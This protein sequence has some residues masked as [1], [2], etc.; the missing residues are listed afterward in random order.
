MFAPLEDIAFFQRVQVDPEAGTIVWPNEVDF[1]PDVLYSWSLGNPYRSS[2]SQRGMNRRPV[3]ADHPTPSLQNGVG[4]LAGDIIV[5][6]CWKAILNLMGSLWGIFLF[7]PAGVAAVEWTFKDPKEVVSTEHFQW[8]EVREGL[9]QGATEW[10]P[11]FYLRLPAEGL[12]ARRFSRL[13][14]RLYSSAPADEL[15]IYYRAPNGQWA[16]GKSW[17][18]VA[19][20]A[21]YRVDLNQADWSEAGSAASQR[22]GGEEK[23]VLSFRLDPGN[24]EGRWIAVQGVRLE[25]A[26]GDF[27]PGCQPEKVGPGRLAEVEAPAQVTAGEEIPVAVRMDLEPSVPGGHGTGYLWLRRGGAVVGLEVFPVDLADAEVDGQARFPTSPYAMPG[28]FTLQAG[29]LER[30]VAGAGWGRDLA[31]V[32][33]V[34]PRAGTVQPP[35]AEVRPLGG[36][37]ALFV[38]GKPVPAFLVSTNSPQR[39]RRHREFAEAGLH[40]YSDWFGT[41]GAGDLGQVKAGIYDYGTYDRYFAE[42]LQA[43]P[44]AYFLPH[45]GITAPLWWQEAHPEERCLYADGSRGPS[46]F[47]SEKWRQETAEDLRRLIHH[48]QTAPYADRILGYIPY[49]GYSAEWQS[50][51]LWD[52][53]LADYSEPARRAWH[54]WLAQRYPTDSALQAA[55]H[56]PGVARETAPLPTPEQRH[57]AAWG[58]LRDPASERNV[59]DFY[60]FLAQLTAETIGYFARVI[61]EAC[62]GR[63]LVGTYYGYLTQH[64][65]RQQDSS[66]LALAQVL[67]FP[68]VDFL[69]SP[70]LY[71]GRELGGTPGFMSATESVLRHGKLWLSEA[72]YRTYLSDPAAGYGR[73]DT[74][75]T[76]RAVLWREFGHVLTHRSAVSW[77]DMADG[78]LSGPD[79]RRELG[80]MQDLLQDSLLQREPFH[81]D[82]AVVVDEASFTYLRPRHEINA[83]LSL[84][85]VVAMP[86]VGVA[87]DFYLLS[88]LADP[89]LPPHKLYLFLN[90]FKV[91]EAQRQAL[92][93]RLRREGAT[94]VWIYAAGFY[95]EAACGPAEMARLTG[96]A[97]AQ[98]QWE[99]PLWV[100]K[101]DHPLVAGLPEATLAGA[102]VAISPAFV[103]EDAAADGLGRLRGSAEVGLAR[104]AMDGWTSIYCAAPLLTPALLRQLARAAGA[105]VYLETGDALSVDNRFLCLHAAADGD[106]ALHLPA[107]AT[108][109]DALSGVVLAQGT[110]FVTLPMRR[111]ETRLLEILSP[112][113][114]AP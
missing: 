33:L 57:A 16:L 17:P 1:C 55:W 93:A 62:R 11:Y 47:A 102:D 40:L 111:G 9:F 114:K 13:T 74:P 82:V 73:T 24:Q 34:N 27:V 50:W 7:F 58:V 20:W 4:S 52:D 92:H 96:I 100:E 53:H 59:I 19:G 22:W 51:G 97:V 67:R 71:T 28:D 65:P 37:P 89:I 3:L 108:V 5:C 103:V 45:I 105:H 79:L 23:R 49:S 77:Y 12:D 38:N 44:Q 106:K 88:D 98:R 8:A 86:R 70:P 78:W 75:A 18:I 56:Q 107:P 66:H 68:E 41:S 43:D 46:S 6:S 32:K 87:W 10:D 104:R 83:L 2:A 91:T 15:S 113:R 64:G 30:D 95:G 81:A 42:V 76:S 25:E 29:I 39:A 84:Q 110:T 48:L 99:G 61:K 26:E 60:Q 54:R 101:G 21:T 63:S 69:M 35:L 90:A 80:R 109:R 31:T 85:P 112:D 94:A 36:A 14:V 72:D